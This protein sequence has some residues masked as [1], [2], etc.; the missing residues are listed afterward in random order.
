MFDGNFKATRK[1]NLSGRRTPYASSSLSSL[2]AAS[3]SLSSSSTSK[4]QLMLQAKLAREERQ[5]QKRRTSASTKIQ[6]LY[7][8]IA[9]STRARTDVFCALELELT[10]LLTTVDIKTTA[11][12]THALV[13]F[14]R[15]FWFAFGRDLRKNMGSLTHPVVGD[16]WLGMA[17]VARQRVLNVQSYLVFMVLVSCLRGT[18]HDANFLAAQKDATWVYQVCA[19]CTLLK[20]IIERMQMLMLMLPCSASVITR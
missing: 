1:V 10:Q 8:R 16:R 20:R 6:A 13:V 4:E 9:A 15:K 7:R 2:T 18:S 11:L 12:P 14:L 5:E 17:G 3:S 19:A